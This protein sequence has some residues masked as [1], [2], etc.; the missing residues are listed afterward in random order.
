MGYYYITSAE[1]AVPP[2]SWAMPKT[3]TPGSPVKERGHR[4][5]S[6]PLAR[7][8]SRDPLGAAGMIS[9]GLWLYNPESRR[10][11]NKKFHVEEAI[12]P[13]YTE[14]DDV[15]ESKRTIQ[16]D[17]VTLYG[18]VKNNPVQRADLL[19]LRLIVRGCSAKQEERLRN[20]WEAA[21]RAVETKEYKDCLCNKKHADCL[22][23]KCR[24]QTTII[25]CERPGHYDWCKGSECA[26]GQNPTGPGVPGGEIHLC[27]PQVF[28]SNKCDMPGCTLLH[29]AMHNCRGLGEL[30]PRRAEYCFDNT[31]GARNDPSP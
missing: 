17:L 22:L 20:N 25:V 27:L 1:N 28:D 21:C 7:W 18:F 8:P 23:G 16:D 30:W 14:N 31:C 12:Q 15:G 2:K 24:N 26:R 10:W 5:Y 6:A 19:G 9:S 29:E 4:Y 3:H 11:E 13:L